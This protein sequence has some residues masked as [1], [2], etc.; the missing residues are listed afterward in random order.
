MAD[1]FLR[2]YG[3]NIFASAYRTWHSSR[4]SVGSCM[5]TQPGS[6][7]LGDR[8]SQYHTADR[9]CT[10][11]VAAGTWRRSR[12]GRSGTCTGRHRVASTCRRFGT[13]DV[14]GIC[15]KSRS[16]GWSLREKGQFI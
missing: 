10:G 2:F 7:D 1:Y 12:P 6:L 5:R 3:D 4:A 15:P 14:R 16:V 8:G 13:A 9:R 11:Y